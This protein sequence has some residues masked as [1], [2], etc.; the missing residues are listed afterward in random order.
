MC[1]LGVAVILLPIYG[2][3]SPQKKQFWGREKAFPS[4]TR[5]IFKLSYYK[6]YSMDSNQILSDDKDPEVLSL[7]D[8]KIRPT[9]PR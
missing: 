9:N 2:V 1:L 7:G 6:N 4:Q 3:E 8:P 5:K